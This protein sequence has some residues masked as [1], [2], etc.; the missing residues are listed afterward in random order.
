MSSGSRC[1]FPD[2]QAWP[3]TVH[4]EF[5]VWFRAASDISMMALITIAQTI[6][7]AIIAHPS[8]ETLSQ[9]VARQNSLN[10]WFE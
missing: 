1:S 9:L 6:K 4:Y 3:G 7:P 10:K 8:L 2:A 5:L